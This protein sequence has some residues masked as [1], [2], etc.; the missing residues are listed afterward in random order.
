MNVLQEELNA[1][2]NANVLGVKIK[3]IALKRSKMKLL[4]KRDVIVKNH[5]AEKSIVN[6]LIEVNIVQMNAIVLIVKIDLQVKIINVVN[7]QN[8]FKI[9]RSK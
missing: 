6:V 7:L 9:K 1:T 3:R 5:F 2:A 4:R 8:K